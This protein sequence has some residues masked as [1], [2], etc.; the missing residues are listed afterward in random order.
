MKQRCGQQAERRVCVASND[1]KKWDEASG[2]CH[3]EV[4]FILGKRSFHEI[5]G[6]M[7]RKSGGWS[8]YV[9]SG[10]GHGEKS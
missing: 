6:K 7:L 2:G 10:R 5:V 8:W 3:L 9:I 1:S 4:T